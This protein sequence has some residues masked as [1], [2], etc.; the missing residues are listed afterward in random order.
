[1]ANL[2]SSKKDVKTSRIHSGRNSARLS[3]IKTTTKKLLEALKTNDVETA[4]KLLVVAESKIARA[5]GK[6]VLKK[7]TAGRKISRLAKKV[8]AATR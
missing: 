3:E 4:K 2:K 6:G 7:N 1:M 5:K 8:S